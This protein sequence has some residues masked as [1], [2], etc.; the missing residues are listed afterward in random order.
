MTLEA[1]QLQITDNLNEFLGNNP[2]V[3][4]ITFVFAHP[5]DIEGYAGGLVNRLAKINASRNQEERYSLNFVVVTDGANGTKDAT[6][7]AELVRTRQ[8]EQLEG[9]KVLFNSPEGEEPE[10]LISTQQGQQKYAFTQ[11]NASVTFLNHQDSNVDQERL[12]NELEVV[13]AESGGDLIITH[14]SR[15]WG[16]PVSEENPYLAV[17]NHSDHRAVS[18]SVSNLL[19]KLE[20]AGVENIPILLRPTWEASDISVGFESNNKK[21][22]LSK[23][24]SQYSV[25]Q[26]EMNKIVDELN[27]VGSERFE[28]FELVDLEEEHTTVFRNT[29]LSLAGEQARL[30]MKPEQQLAETFTR[31]NIRNVLLLGEIP[32]EPWKLNDSNVTKLLLTIENWNRDIFERYIRENKIDFLV[33]PSD[34]PVNILDDIHSVMMFLSSVNHEGFEA[35]DTQKIQGAAYALQKT[36]GTTLN[37]FIINIGLW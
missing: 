3:K 26:L 23:H 4:N 13:L 18:K 28:F 22:A 15:E 24:D 37:D 30:L 33:I 1:E 31:F 6:D 8:Q 36:K 7:R 35:Q 14:D 29:L 17:Q 10:E 19:A 5:D 12:V 16:R 21:L 2:Q 25:N 32:E 20:D 11:A 9:L 27:A 34:L